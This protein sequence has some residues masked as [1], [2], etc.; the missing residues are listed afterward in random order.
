MTVNVN[1]AWSA[2]IEKMSGEETPPGHD[3]RLTRAMKAYH[4]TKARHP[5]DLPEWLFDERERRPALHSR[6]VNSQF[7]S[8]EYDASFHRV[9]VTF[10][11][12]DNGIL[13]A[14]QPRHARTQSQPL[15]NHGST[16]SKT[17]DRLRALRDA[18]RADLGVR[19]RALPSPEIVVQKPLP[20]R[21]GAF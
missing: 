9:P 8:T 19:H 14:P 21:P 4:L 3:S 7:E 20:V 18:K 15:S 10:S 1:K 17:A 16:S 12:F 11:A 6:V 5:T 2:K 13:Q